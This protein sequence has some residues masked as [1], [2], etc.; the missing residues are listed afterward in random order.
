MLLDSEASGD[1]WLIP[2]ICTNKFGL[3]AAQHHITAMFW[4]WLIINPFQNQDPADD[5]HIQSLSP[6]KNLQELPPIDLGCYSHNIEPFRDKDRR[7]KKKPNVGDGSRKDGIA[8][9]SASIDLP[10][11]VFIDSL[12]IHHLETHGEDDHDFENLNL[13]GMRVILSVLKSP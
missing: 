2:I 3:I 5:L 9:F 12:Q 11:I 8:N 7:E 10:P 1:W 13:V 4:K 6:R